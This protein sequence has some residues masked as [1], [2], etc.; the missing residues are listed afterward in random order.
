MFVTFTGEKIKHARH[1]KE[2][3]LKEYYA[4]HGITPHH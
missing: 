3:A 1:E 2:T 4:N